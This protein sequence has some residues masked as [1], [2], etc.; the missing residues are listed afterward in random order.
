MGSNGENGEGR[1]KPYDVPMTCKAK[2]SKKQPTKSMVINEL[3][4]ALEDLNL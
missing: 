4:W 2:E 1:G 3:W